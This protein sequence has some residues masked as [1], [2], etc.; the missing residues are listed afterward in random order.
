MGTGRFAEA[1]LVA[2]YALTLVFFGLFTGRVNPLFFGEGAE[3]VFPLYAHAS[4]VGQF[5]LLFAVGLFARRAAPGA[6]GRPVAA[7]ASALLVAGYALSLRQALRGAGPAWLAACA[8]ALFGA[9]QGAGLLSWSLAYARMPAQQAA[10]CMVASTL[11]SAAL[12][13]ALGLLRS[14][15]ALFGALGAVVALDCALM[16]REA[17]CPGRLPAGATGGQ[18]SMRGRAAFRTWALASRRSLLC[19]FALAF[20]CGAQ[21]AISLDSFISQEAS[22]WLF[23]LGYALGALLFYATPV[24]KNG[25]DGYYAMYTSLLAVMATCG[26]LSFVQ[27]PAVQTVLYAA[28]NIAF[29]IVSICVVMMALG[30]ARETGR[31][32][33]FTVGTICGAMYFSIQLGRV[34]CDAAMGLAGTSTIGALVVSVIIVYVLALAAISSGAFVRRAGGAGEPGGEAPARTVV[35]VASVTEESIRSNPVYRERYGMTDREMDVLVLL[36]A[37]YNATDIASLLGI[38]PNTVKTHLKSLYSK[39]GVHNRR[40]MVELLNEVEAERAK[41]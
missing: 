28:D 18:D 3:E 26:V 30:A 15:S 34:V 33:T 24:A 40:E 8:G 9:G 25:E 41:G 11:L 6:G 37:G 22:A 36:L 35:S 31:S 38:S 10:R 39:T 5:A 21:R 4:E 20:V 12:L 16:A 7:L 2:G 27:S 17:A 32:T 19:L 23:P 1:R 14:P 13:A 29:T